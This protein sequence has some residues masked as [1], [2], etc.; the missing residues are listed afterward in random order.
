MESY[1]NKLND[2]QYEAVTT[3][4]GPLLVLAGAGSGKTTVLANRIAYILQTR[5]VEPW[6]I[7]AITFT[8]KA[9]REMKTRIEGIV[10]NAVNE[11]WVGTFHSVCVKMLR[12][13]IHLAG[14]GSDF[15]IFDTSDCRTVMKECAKELGLDDKQYPV[16]YL[17][18]EIS[19]AKNEMLFPED[20]QNSLSHDPV[21][22]AVGEAYALYRDKLKACNAVDFDDL[23]MLTVMILREN[24]EAAERYQAQFKYILV[25]EYQDTN[26]IQ[27]ELVKL[28]AKGYGNICVVG[29]DDQ[30]I[31]KFRGANVNNILG[32]ENDYCNAKR[33][34]L[35]QNYRSTKVILDAANGVIANNTKRLGKKLWTDR[36]EGE[37]ISVFAAPS[38]REEAKY[39]AERIK[40]HCDKT[41]Q[42]NDCAI[43]YRTNAQS[44]ALEE[45]LMQERIPYK[46]LAGTRF[47]DRKEIKDIIA[48]LRLIYNFS[49][50][51]SLERIINEPKRKIG[52]ATLDK[53]RAHAEE[54]GESFYSIIKNAELYGDLKSSA[55]RLTAF[56][57]LIR[58]LR[59]TAAELDIEQF[60]KKVIKDTGYMDMLDADS[61][62]EAETRRDNI[63]EFVNLV[64]EYAEDPN[65]SGSLSDFLENITLRSDADGLDE[66]E[67]YVALMTVH[68]AKGLEFPIVFLTGMEE[69]IFP[70]MM[71]FDAEEELEEERRLCY[72]AIT[73]AK[74]KLYLTR[75]MS[76]FRFGMRTPHNESRFMTE[77]PKECVRLD[78]AALNRTIEKLERIGIS[79]RA[80]RKTMA[81]SLKKPTAA[82]GA[83]DFKKGE[84]VS[85]RKF[86][87]GT[88]ISSQSFGNDAIV[89]VDFENVGQKRLMAAFAKLERI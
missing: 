21:V 52:N 12:R 66:S 71:T 43:L 75:A 77:V 85:H 18:R 47:Y 2:A 48:Y 73:R 16:N 88:V 40:A 20:M 63:N 39:V 42:Y 19:R 26:D 54:L 37:P 70:G 58:E 51:V 62:V 8:N 56:A 45:V 78:G 30:S 14:Y 82:V 31:Y 89:V 33:I 34:S 3:T 53:V 25:D 72:V 50:N 49:D 28:L 46:V 1:L 11:M 61:S 65:T 79:V 60:V 84:K 59:K 4:E 5:S 57:E 10:G 6:N 87:T 23:I 41:K 44:R 80:D 86:G 76:R 38:E 7:L 64:S 55:A 36:T 22:K 69:G 15:V 74:N 68:S 35:E 17:L 27:Y 81:D 67:N 83:Y 29:D 9:A 13:Y 24:D 32:F